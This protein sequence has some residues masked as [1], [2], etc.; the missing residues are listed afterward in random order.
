MTGPGS[1]GV[2]FVLGLGAS[3]VT[4]ILLVFGAN[5]LLSP[6]RPT[7]QKCAPYECGMEQAGR[8]WAPV[9]I[10]FATIAL[11][12]VLFD[13][14]TALLFAVGPSLRGSLTAL[15]ETLAFTG[16]LA[17]GLLYAWRKGALKWPS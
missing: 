2:L 11:L 17:F 8:P 5:A 1:E 14:E 9:N 16:F 4:F 7:A 6:R 13:A 3:A 12:F 15:V 10:R